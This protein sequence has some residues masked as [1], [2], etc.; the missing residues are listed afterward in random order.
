[1]TRAPLS[2]MIVRIRIVGYSG[3]IGTYAAPARRIPWIATI[4]SGERGTITATHSSRS[5]FLVA[6]HLRDV[7]HGGVE[8]RIAERPAR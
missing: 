2:S 8:L 4:S 7:I 1:M 3:S 5:T 6:Q